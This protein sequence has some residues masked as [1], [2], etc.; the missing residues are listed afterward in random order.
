MKYFYILFIFLCSSVLNAQLDSEITNKLTDFSAKISK[1]YVNLHWKIVNPIDLEKINIEMK[2]AGS[3]FY[4]FLNDVNVL[5][6]DRKEIRDSLINYYYSFRSKPKENG[7]YF[8]KIELVDKGNKKISSNEIKVGI[9]EIAEFK[10]FQN[11]PN[12]FNPSTIISY[13]LYSPSNVSLKIYT[14][15]GK[16]IGVLIDEFQNPG[17]YRIEFNANDFKDLSSGIYFY[18]LQTKYSSDIKKMIFT[19]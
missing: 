3:D 13:E 12:P 8:Y 1:G 14:L 9:S 16:Q 15:N 4:Q 7:V 10:L 19:K 17:T 11:K 18:K 2:K 5:N 6:Y